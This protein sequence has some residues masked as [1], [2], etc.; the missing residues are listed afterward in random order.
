[1][2]IDKS[3]EIELLKFLREFSKL[4]TRKILE[5]DQF[6]SVIWFSD[7]PQ[8][9]ECDVITRHLD[10][11]D[12]NYDQW[13]EI[14]KPKIIEYP[15]PPPIIRDWIKDQDL[16][17]YTQDLKPFPY[18]IKE[19]L[20]VNGEVFTQKISLEESPK[21]SQAF[22]IYYQQQWL[23]WA[24][25]RKRIE[26]IQKL[27]NKLYNIYQK[28]KNLS[29]SYQIVLGLGLL[30][31][32]NSK[33]QHIKRHIVTTPFSIE[34]NLQTGTII[35]KPEEQN[36][37]LSLE[38]EMLD[39]TEIPDESEENINKK[40]NQLG[41]DFWSNN[42]FYNCLKSWI[43]SYDSEGQFYK[44]I[45]LEQLSKDRKQLFFSSCYYFETTWNA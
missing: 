9:K 30:S 17:S 16:L 2:D 12:I 38:L 44:N 32:Q 45:H 33:K 41:N 40:L 20:G 23:P 28:Y 24:K 43:H 42:E 19:S 15:K 35:I 39:P 3:T 34:F 10:K 6:E 37:E 14:K 29:E 25:E 22:D 8:E 13:I 36:M 5:V 26:S 31:T 27:Y 11:Q 18:T 7:I 21:V 1:M 4:R